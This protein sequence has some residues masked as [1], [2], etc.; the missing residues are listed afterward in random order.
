[1]VPATSSTIPSDPTSEL[2]EWM[3]KVFVSLRE[4]EVR[5]LL[6]ESPPQLKHSA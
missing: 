1:M 4:I 3:G 5:L 2:Y 6:G